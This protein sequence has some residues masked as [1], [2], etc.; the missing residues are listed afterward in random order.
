ME[1]EQI[2]K[3]K[4]ELKM[5]IKNAINNFMAKQPL[6]IPSVIVQS[7]KENCMGQ[8]FVVSVDVKVTIEL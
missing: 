8:E 6:I 3:D 4:Q 2:L 1:I 5:A 7:A